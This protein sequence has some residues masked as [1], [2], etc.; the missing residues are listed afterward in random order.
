MARKVRCCITGEYGTSDTFYRDEKT[1]RYYKNKEVFDNWRAQ[2]DK[3]NEVLDII[4]DIVGYYNG[5]K[6]PSSITKKLKDLEE[7]YD[8]FTVY[9]TF[10]EKRDDIQFAI[11]TRDFDT[12]YGKCAYI[13]AIVVN[14]INDIWIRRKREEKTKL[15]QEATLKSEDMDFDYIPAPV[16]KNTKDISQFLEDNLWN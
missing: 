3:R 12:E 6:F 10:V 13:M 14:N 7:I 11:D 9:D 16:K 5:E 1:K 8:I 15:K 4:A 2:T